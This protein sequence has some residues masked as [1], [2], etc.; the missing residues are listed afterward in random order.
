AIARWLS[1][2][3]EFEVLSALAA[4]AYENPDD[5]FPEIMTAPTCYDGQDLGHP[6][7]P[8][9]RCVRNDVRLDADVRLLMVSGSN[10]SGKSTLL[11]TVGINAVLPLAGAPVRPTPLWISPL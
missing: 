9:A 5:A 7:L 2:V 3:G 11:R 8:R 10:M 6:L 4:Y 1:A